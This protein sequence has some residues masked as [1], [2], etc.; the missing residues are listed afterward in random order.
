MLSIFWLPFSLSEENVIILKLILYQLIHYFQINSIVTSIQ[1]FLH[2]KEAFAT[3]FPIRNFHS[4]SRFSR[5]RQRVDIPK[6]L[7]SFC[8]FREAGSWVDIINPSEQSC[9]GKALAWSQQ[10]SSWPLSTHRSS[11]TIFDPLSSHWWTYVFGG[12]WRKAMGRNAV[13]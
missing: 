9:W 7:L 2:G 5:V 11:L 13:L 3:S 8:K 1:L 4:L 6:K 12:R 10:F